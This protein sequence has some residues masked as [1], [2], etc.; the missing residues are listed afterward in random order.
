MSQY[1]TEEEIL[2]YCTSQAGV[3]VADVKIAS[4]LIDGYLGKSFEAKEIS[5]T[6]KVIRRRGKLNHYPILSIKSAKEIITTPI[7][8]SKQEIDVNQ[9]VLDV[10][11]DG[12]FSYVAP[13]SPFAFDVYGLGIHTLSLHT[14][15]KKLE[16]TYSYGYEDVPE[17]IKLVTAMLAQNI[18]QMQSFVGFK[19]L[20]T[21]DYTIEMSNPSFFTSD[22]QTVL[23]KY[24]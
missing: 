15:M 11:S 3:T 16:V 1:L 12:Y 7:G 22:M 21:L 8:L 9:I 18:R 5:E 20:N 19:R 2:T 17:D 23:N 4:A 14:P 13:A 6:V 10:E 24:R